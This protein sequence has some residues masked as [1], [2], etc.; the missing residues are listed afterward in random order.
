VA[1]TGI[2]DR[3]DRMPEIASALKAWSDRVLQTASRQKRGRATVLAY[4]RR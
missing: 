4:G 1:V 3:F 2:Y